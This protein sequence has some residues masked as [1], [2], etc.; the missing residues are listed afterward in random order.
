MYVGFGAGV[1]VTLIGG[2]AGG[3]EGDKSQAARDYVN[4]IDLANLPENLGFS[5]T[6]APVIAPFSLA[7]KT[8]AG[9]SGTSTVKA[10]AVNVLSEDNTGTYSMAGGVGV[11]LLGVGA[12]VTVVKTDA[13]VQNFARKESERLAGKSQWS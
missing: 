5:G 12:S 1:N 11:G 13:T 10:S 6:A 7:Y 3:N 2:K 9:I 4:G 8:A